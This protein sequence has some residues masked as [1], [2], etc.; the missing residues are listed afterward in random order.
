MN[1]ISHNVYLQYNTRMLLNKPGFRLQA[2]QAVH[3]LKRFYLGF[4]VEVERQ[5]ECD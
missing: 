4:W 2:N 1:L 5:D 3:Y